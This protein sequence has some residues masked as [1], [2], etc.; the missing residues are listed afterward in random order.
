MTLEEPPAPPPVFVFC[1]FLDGA[2]STEESELDRRR[3]PLSDIEGGGR[4]VFEELWV[5]N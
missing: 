1:D 3:F 2:E 4:K 5:T